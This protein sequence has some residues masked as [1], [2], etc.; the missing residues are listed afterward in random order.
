MNN[1]NNVDNSNQCQKFPE[2]IFFARV[3]SGVFENKHTFTEQKTVLYITTF[4]YCKGRLVLCTL[5]N[6]N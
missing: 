2:N 6:T 1:N 5:F 4:M 3:Q